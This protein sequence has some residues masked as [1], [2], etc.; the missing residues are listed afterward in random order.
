MKKRKDSEKKNKKDKGNKLL[1]DYIAFGNK[2][3]VFWSI[4][5]FA[6]ILTLISIPTILQN[7]IIGNKTMLK[8]FLIIWILEIIYIWFYVRGKRELKIKT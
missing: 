1:N 4:T 7:S 8:S 6:V 3:K 5:F 2:K